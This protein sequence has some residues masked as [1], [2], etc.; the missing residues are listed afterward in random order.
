M[1]EGRNVRLSG[2]D[3]GRGTF[4]HRHVMLVDQQTNKIHI[5]LNHMEDDQEGYLE[6][7]NSILSEEAVLAYEYGM[8]YDNPDHLFVWEAQ[9][10]DFFNGAQIV[11]DTYIGSGEKKW[12]RSNGLVMLLPHGMDGAASE[13][14]SCRIERFLQMTDSLEAAPDSEDVNMQVVN[15]TTPAQYFHILRRQMV[16]NYRKPLVVVAPKILIRS[17][18]CVSS[19]SEFT[20]GT[21]FHPIIGDYLADPIKVKRVILTSGKH[22]YELHRERVRAKIDDVAII[23]VESLCPFPL[24]AIQQELERYTNARKFIWSQ[25]EHR[26]QGAWTFIQPRFENLLGRRIQ[27]A[28]RPESA[29]PAVGAKVLH[30]A[31]VEHVLKEPLYNMK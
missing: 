24:H 29:V 14:S 1:M 11:L 9:F 13:H 2:E 6:V 12:I 16:R 31:E 3:V 26:N 30:Q 8:A 17:T 4:S 18:D 22:F 23:R 19:L 20:N 21:H 15:P 28:G 25:E 27:Y 5:P 7:A 10:G